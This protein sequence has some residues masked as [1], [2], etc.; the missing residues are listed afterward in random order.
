MTS[1]ALRLTVFFAAIGLFTTAAA[2][3]R[4]EDTEA[5]VLAKALKDTT[6]TLQDGLKTS[7]REGKPISGKFEIEHDALQLSVYKLKGDDFTEVV[8]D[9]KTCAIAKAEKI[10]DADDL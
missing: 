9:P 10:T 6:V 5:A 4:A 8:A 7:E 3:V 1:T 2:S